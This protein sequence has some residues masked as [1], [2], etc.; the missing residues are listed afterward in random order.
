MI[1]FV[2]LVLTD[3]QAETLAPLVATELPRRPVLFLSS[4]A[5]NW[6]GDKGDVVWRWQVCRLDWRRAQ[7]VLKILDG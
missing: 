2:Q 6:D 3:E 1:N 7:R 4:A 5:P